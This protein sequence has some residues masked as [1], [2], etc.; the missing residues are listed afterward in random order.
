MGAADEA[1][2]WVR[3]RFVLVGALGLLIGGEFIRVVLAMCVCLLVDRSKCYGEHLCICVG[4]D[5]I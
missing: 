3:A 1:M 4:L 5:L 2:D